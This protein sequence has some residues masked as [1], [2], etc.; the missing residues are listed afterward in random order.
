MK[1]RYT[2][3]IATL[4][5]PMLLGCGSGQL[6]DDSDPNRTDGGGS[7]GDGGVG[8]AAGLPCDVAALLQKNC[9]GCHG[10]TPA[11]G[12]P[13]SLVS[14][15]DLSKAAPQGGTWAARSLSRM[16]DATRPMPPKPAPAVSAA[17]VATFSA[18]VTGGLPMMRCD[19][20]MD[21]PF[22]APPICTSGTS[23]NRGNRESPKMNPG[24]ACIACHQTNR[25]APRFLAAGTVYPTAHEPDLCNAPS[26]VVA[27]AVVELTAAD[28]VVRRLP[29]N[30]VGNFY[31]EGTS[32]LTKPYRARLLYQGRVRAMATPQQD[33]DCNGCHTQSGINGAPGRIVLP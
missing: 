31:L 17:E 22:S 2:T 24:K 21:D 18:W 26:D 14:H 11:G 7:P 20:K 6:I 28:G 4:I 27:G 32:G 13:V 5:F 3:R 33:G 15:A 10:A 19:I 16:Q 1:N 25:E 30:S 23:W 9:W 8:G 29:V 12:A